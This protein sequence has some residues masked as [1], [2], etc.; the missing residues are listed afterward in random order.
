VRLELELQRGLPLHGVQISL[1]GALE[2]RAR[3]ARGVPD[4]FER[5]QAVEMG[6]AVAVL[7]VA[8]VVMAADAV[9]LARVADDR[10]GDVGRGHLGQ[11]AAQAAFLEGQVLNGGGN[12]F[13]MFDELRLAGGEA[14][15]LAALA[16]IIHPGQQGEFGVGIQAQPGYSRLH[17]RTPAVEGSSVVASHT[18]R[19]LTTRCCQQSRS[20]AFQITS[21]QLREASIVASVSILRGTEDT[22]APSVL[23]G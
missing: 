2:E 7:L 12:Q 15:V 11:P 10:V 23:A 4:F 6:Q 13:E 16:L 19:A 5:A 20:S 8:L 3:V 14:P 1:G 17:Q 9:V 21:Y 18:T 22:L